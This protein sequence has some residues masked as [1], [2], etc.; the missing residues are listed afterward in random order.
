MNLLG[1]ERSCPPDIDEKDLR[2][3]YGPPTITL[4][5]SSR[6]PRLLLLLLQPLEFST[7]LPMFGIKGIGTAK[8]ASA[9]HSFL[10]V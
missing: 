9:S 8:I 7:L 1:Q 4:G 5:P 3:A 10:P 6:H 2:Y